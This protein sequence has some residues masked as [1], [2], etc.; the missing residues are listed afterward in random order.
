[1]DAFILRMEFPGEFRR[2]ACVEE[3]GIW[4]CNAEGKRERICCK[5]FECF[6]VRK[7]TTIEFAVQSDFEAFEF[8]G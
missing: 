1:M 8:L 3:D 7:W 4:I 5:T 6:P 2:G